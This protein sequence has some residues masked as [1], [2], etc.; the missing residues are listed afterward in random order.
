MKARVSENFFFEKWTGTFQFPS[1]GK[2]F[3][4]S[5]VRCISER[6]KNFP[7]K[8]M[9]QKRSEGRLSEGI[10]TFRRGF[11]FTSE[12]STSEGIESFPP[13]VFTFRGKLFF[14]SDLHLPSEGKKTFRGKE[15]FSLK[16]E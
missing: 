1:K 13:N 16:T 3:I 14:F 15:D 6:I 5:E 8:V 9:G 4:P 10:K 11:F 7:L 2:D 12:G